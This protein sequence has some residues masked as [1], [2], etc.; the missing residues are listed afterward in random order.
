MGIL[1]R[2]M[3]VFFKPR[4]TVEHGGSPESI[5]QGTEHPVA[6]TSF[7]PGYLSQGITGSTKLCVYTVIT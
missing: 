3:Q 1:K 5:S 4:V 2:I 6:S 7:Q